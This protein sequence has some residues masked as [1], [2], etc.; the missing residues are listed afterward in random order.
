MPVHTNV[1]NAPATRPV[2]QRTIA[3]LLGGLALLG[4][5]SVDAYLPDVSLPGITGGRMAAA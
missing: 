4:P 2:V 5:L 1:S 3:T